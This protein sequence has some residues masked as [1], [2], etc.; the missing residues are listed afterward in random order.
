M[1]GA[2]PTPIASSGRGRSPS[3]GP[4]T[5]QQ[6]CAYRREG[7]WCT[8]CHVLHM[9]RR[10]FRKH[11][12]QAIN[13]HSLEAGSHTP[14]FV[15]ARYLVSCLAAF[16][17]AVNAREQWYGCPQGPGDGSQT[18]PAPRVSRRGRPIVPRP[19]M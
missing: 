11:L 5:A 7:G 1:T 14:D 10:G 4:C 18:G 19:E 16:D 15:L 6:P 12:E 9:I 17:A 13:R 2:A 3:T 8:F